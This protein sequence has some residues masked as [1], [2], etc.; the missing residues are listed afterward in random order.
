M[1][2]VSFMEE[3]CQGLE[4][5]LEKNMT[6]SRRE[7]NKIEV[8]DQNGVSVS[9]DFRYDLCTVTLAGWHHGEHWA[10]SLCQPLV[11]SSVFPN[12]HHLWY[13]HVGC[14]SLAFPSSFTHTL[15]MALG[16][17]SYCQIKQSMYHSSEH[18]KCLPRLLL[19]Q[20]YKQMETGG[21]GN[22]VSPTPNPAQESLLWSRLSL[23]NL[24]NQ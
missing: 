4:Q 12:Y 18:S 17:P 22:A 8:S 3:N 7:T 14:L 24:K 19:F 11:T 5:S 15:E 23:A 9:C 2:N 13:Q 20:C 1:Y 21:R 16:I 10:Y 6:N